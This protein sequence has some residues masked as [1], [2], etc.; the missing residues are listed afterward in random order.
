MAVLGRVLQHAV[1]QVGG[2]DHPRTPSVGEPG[3]A[4]TA[5]GD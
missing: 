4:G 3:G 1:D 2:G 5:A